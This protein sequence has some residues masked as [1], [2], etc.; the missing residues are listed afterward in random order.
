[1]SDEDNLRD[2]QD[3]IEGLTGQ[4]PAS[5]F[6]AGL[7]EYPD[8]ETHYHR[9]VAGLSVTVLNCRTQRRYPVSSTGTMGTLS[10]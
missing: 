5:G 8:A 10:S 4:L 2:I 3:V 7:T 9:V 6:I 1:M